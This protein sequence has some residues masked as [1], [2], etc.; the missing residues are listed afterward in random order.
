MAKI[1]LQNVE[2]NGPLEFEQNEDDR[3]VSRPRDTFF[4]NCRY[5]LAIQ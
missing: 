3:T 4:I 2:A 5:R 1:Y